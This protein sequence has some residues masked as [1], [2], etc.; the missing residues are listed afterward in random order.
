MAR[1]RKISLDSSADILLT[2][3][4]LSIAD[5]GY[6]DQAWCHAD[7]F[8]PRANNGVV[9]MA[10]SVAIGGRSLQ[11]TASLTW[12]PESA[13]LEGVVDGHDG[14]TDWQYRFAAHN[15]RV[16]LVSKKPFGFHEKHLLLANSGPGLLL[17]SYFDGTRVVMNAA[18][19]AALD[20]APALLLVGSKP[21]AE[22][23]LEGIPPAV[24]AGPG[25][26]EVMTVVW[27]ADSDPFQIARSFQTARAK[28]LLVAGYVAD[29]DGTDTPW[30]FASVVIRLG[31][32][33]DHVHDNV[34]GGLRV[35]FR[36][37]QAVAHVTTTYDKIW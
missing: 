31:E 23:F 19:Y 10:G 16:K 13:A 15:G 12:R 1:T 36:A 37:R 33:A 35:D 5:M 24:A 26:P 21:R 9:Q 7:L 8:L 17:G 11:I 4:R 3:V 14:I 32:D 18:R 34:Y 20:Y 22:R 2:A 27:G 29:E 28:R 30:Q 6:G 25:L